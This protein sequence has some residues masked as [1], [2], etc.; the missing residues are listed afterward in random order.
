MSYVGPIPYHSY[1]QVPPRMSATL[2]LA[3]ILAAS[4]FVTL[5]L[6]TAAVAVKLEPAQLNA[7]IVA[8]P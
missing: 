3:L 6:L 8:G 2:M 1:R 5:L 4:M 7:L